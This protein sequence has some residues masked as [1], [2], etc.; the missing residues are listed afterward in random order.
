MV[1][2][3]GLSIVEHLPGKRLV[4]TWRGVPMPLIARMLATLCLLPIALVLLLF[5]FAQLQTLLDAIGLG[6]GG[7][8]SF[9]ASDH[10][11]VLQFLAT[12]YGSALALY[13]AFGL[14]VFR[15][16]D[17]LGY[18]SRLAW[19]RGGV[20]A[21]F[22]GRFL[23]GSYTFRLP[24]ERLR[25]LAIE[26]VTDAG[27]D[28]CIDCRLAFDDGGRER[29]RVLTLRPG[30]DLRGEAALRR[31]AFGIAQVIGWSGYRAHHVAPGN[32][33]IVLLP[34]ADG[35]DVR[36]IPRPG[37]RADEDRRGAFAQARPA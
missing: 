30:A 6:A 15:I 36:P 29:T 24:T 16:R 17:D 21:R 32:L 13:V 35:R 5:P 28:H 27:G 7:T 11:A 34:R 4:V 2:S 1:A 10:P 18:W 22:S 9:G 33:A 20:V 26:A 31:L 12:W 19:D 8:A 3:A 37:T 14:V 25:C 23:W